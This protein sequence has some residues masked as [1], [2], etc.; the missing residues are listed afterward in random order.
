MKSKRKIQSKLLRDERGKPYLCVSVRE[1][2]LS[3][4]VA[5][6]QE[7]NVATI[8]LTPNAINSW[9]VM[10]FGMTFETLIANVE[11][12]IAGNL[13][14]SRSMPFTLK[15]NM[16]RVSSKK[17]KDSTKPLKNGQSKKSKKSLM[18]R[19]YNKEPKLPKNWGKIR[20]GNKFS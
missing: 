4:Y 7:M 5:V 16:G 2:I 1:I 12:V 11:H 9:A 20:I 10:H 3:A 14:T 17:S 6:R 18:E 15:A 19:I 8:N 13:G